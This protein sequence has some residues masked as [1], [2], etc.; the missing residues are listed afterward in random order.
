M[1]GT[2]T[3][4]GRILVGAGGWETLCQ[5]AVDEMEFILTCSRATAWDST[6]QKCVFN[7]SQVCGSGTELNHEG[8]RCIPD[9]T[10]EEINWGAIAAMIVMVVILGV[11]VTLNVRFFKELRGRTGAPDA[12]VDH[13]VDNKT[14]VEPSASEHTTKKS[15]T[16]AAEI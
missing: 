11:S 1:N 4:I 15:R 10:F 16:S 6:A 7:S 3:Q 12:G 14:N 8:T 9:D 2:E 13:G 5:A